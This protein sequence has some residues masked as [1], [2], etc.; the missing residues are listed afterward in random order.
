MALLMKMFH[1]IGNCVIVMSKHYWDEYQNYF[2]DRNKMIEILKFYQ[3]SVNVLPIIENVKLEQWKK[4]RFGKIHFSD[5]VIKK[6][7][8]E[9]LSSGYRKIY[10]LLNDKCATTELPLYMP[11][12]VIWG[13][14]EA[15]EQGIYSFNFR[16]GLLIKCA[17]VEGNQEYK[18]VLS[19]GI[20]A[21]IAFFLCLEDSVIA[22][23]MGGFIKGILQIGEISQ[24]IR[25][26]YGNMEKK[27]LPLFYPIPI[28]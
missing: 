4:N 7:Y 2:L 15:I 10:D 18:T 13:K 3:K 27:Y 20:K 19:E 26:K 22:Y 5:I 11:L 9:E 6:Y 8:K 25:E 16:E 17:D 23:G 21:E 12:M 14:S 1:I 28:R 24:T